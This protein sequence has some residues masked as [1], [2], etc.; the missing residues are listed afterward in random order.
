MGLKFDLCIKHLDCM[1]SGDTTPTHQ[2]LRFHVADPVF[3][4]TE[5]G[6]LVAVVKQ[7]DVGRKVTL[8]MVA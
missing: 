7:A 5:E 4:G 6:D 2:M 1:I 8:H 3:T